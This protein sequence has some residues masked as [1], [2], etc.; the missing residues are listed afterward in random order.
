MSRTIHLSCSHQPW[1]QTP[2]IRIGW[3]VAKTCPRFPLAPGRE[4][5]DLLGIVIVEAHKTSERKRLPTAICMERFQSIR[6]LISQVPQ[7]GA[8]II[9]HML[10]GNPVEL[11]AASSR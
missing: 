9:Q 7:I 6:D 3:S 2:N 11:E 4:V 1:P 10:P 5:Q 8:D